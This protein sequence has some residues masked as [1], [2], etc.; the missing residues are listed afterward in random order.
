M[1]VGLILTWVNIL[2]LNNALLLF[3]ATGIL[4]CG[5]GM[6]IGEWRETRRFQKLLDKIMN[7]Y[8]FRK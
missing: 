4:Y 2:W 5:L 3:L 6:M 7:E 8:E 1:Y